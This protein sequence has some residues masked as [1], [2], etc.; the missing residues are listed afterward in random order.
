MKCN[1]PGNYVKGRKS[2]TREEQAAISAAVISYMTK[3]M[4]RK[5]PASSHSGNPAIECGKGEVRPLP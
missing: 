3:R 5:P 1:A 2:P 4:I